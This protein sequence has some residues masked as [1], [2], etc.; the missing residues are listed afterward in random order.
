[1][2]WEQ[3]DLQALQ[4]GRHRTHW[5]TLNQRYYHGHPFADSRFVDG[6]LRH[7]GR[8]T[9]C[10]FAHRHDDGTV[11]GMVLLAPRSFG[12][13]RQFIPAQ[14]QAGLLLIP[15]P[16]VVRQLFRALGPTCISLEFLQQDFKYQALDGLD[17]A[18]DVRVQPHSTTMEVL[19]NG[20]FNEYWNARSR[21]LTKN[22]GRIQRRVASQCTSAVVEEIHDPK[23]MA[24]AVQRYG[25]LESAGWKHAVGTA[26]SPDNAQGR[27]YAEI[28]QQFAETSQA[29]AYEFW[30]DGVLAAS[31]LLVSGAGMQ[32]ILKTSYDEQL[33]QFAP[34]RLL[35]RTLLDRSFAAKTHQTIEFYTN[36]SPDQLAWATHQRT[37]SHVTYFRY[38]CLASAH[39]IY[40]RLRLGRRRPT[41][42]VAA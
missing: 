2:T 31:R 5:D 14:L 7:F 19:L 24:A 6:L 17:S 27:F 25:R 39:D 3:L 28:M 37:I 26:L 9:E 22:I 18:P 30:I 36:A 21:N 32:I 10:L 29:T 11:D 8:G 23:E 20:T 12:V 34:G 38:G 41:T 4:L 40:R 33:S 15:N 16:S 35:L 42:A 13:W 1:M